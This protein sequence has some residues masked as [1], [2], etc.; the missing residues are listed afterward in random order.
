NA[1]RL[2]AVEQWGTRQLQSVNP[3]P[4]DTPFRCRWGFFC[5]WV[6]HVIRHLRFDFDGDDVAVFE[7]T[8]LRDVMRSGVFVCEKFMP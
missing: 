6:R 8:P 3:I 7:N 4:I 1:R 2:D 5:V